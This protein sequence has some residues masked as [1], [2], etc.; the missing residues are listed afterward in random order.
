MAIYGNSIGGGPGTL[1][2]AFS[3][4]ATL[5]GRKPRDWLAYFRSFTPAS[6]AMPEAPA[7]KLPAAALALY[8]GSY[9]HPADGP[10]DI[11]LEGEALTGRLRKA[12]RLS[13]R[14]EPLGEHR[15]LMHLVE[16]E[17]RGVAGQER[18][19][20]TFGIEGG[21]SMRADMPG[22]FHG[23]TFKRSMSP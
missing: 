1:A 19:E 23:R 13:F 15:F 9:E 8:A 4:A 6:P 11:R 20:V 14:L 7:V 18:F 3:V 16:P 22:P 17:W 5:L 2:A 12:Y 10:L 21:A